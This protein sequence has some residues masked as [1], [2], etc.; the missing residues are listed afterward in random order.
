TTSIIT[1]TP[2]NN[3]AEEIILYNYDQDGW[4]GNQYYGEDH[5]SAPFVANTTYN[6]SIKLLNEN[7]DPALDITPEIINEGVDHQFI[8]NPSEA[9][10]LQIEY[11][12]PY[13]SN[14]KPIGINF[15]LTTGNDGCVQFMFSLLHK[16]NKDESGSETGNY[17]DLT[18]VE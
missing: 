6:C 13:D 16:P 5:V 15:T 3:N 1:M 17:S 4:N 12:S 18:G 11:A 14:G 10:N 7:V 8:F 9:S 2:V